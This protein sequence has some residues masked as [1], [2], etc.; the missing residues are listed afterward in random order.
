[1]R[2]RWL[3]I[4]VRALGILRLAHAKLAQR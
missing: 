3:L 2:L 4:D 1:M